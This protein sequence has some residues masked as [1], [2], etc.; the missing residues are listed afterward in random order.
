[1][2][3]MDFLEPFA[4]GYLE[5]RVGQMEARAKEKAERRKLEDN[6]KLQNLYS[7]QAYRQQK[8]IDYELIEKERL[9]NRNTLKNDL[10]NEGMP[11]QLLDI[12]PQ[13]HLED[14]NSYNDFVNTMYGDDFNW[15]KKPASYKDVDGK[16]VD[17]TVA[18]LI[19]FANQNE[20]GITKDA[21]KKTLVGSGAV[22]DGYNNVV[23]NQIDIGPTTELPSM[24]A[25]PEELKEQF[26][27]METVT[28][29]VEEYVPDTELPSFIG[30]GTPS[31]FTEDYGVLTEEKKRQR[32]QLIVKNIATLGAFGE[33]LKLIDGEYQM[34]LPA[35]S[36][37][38]KRYNALVETATKFA[39]E[40]YRLKGKSP[41]AVEATQFA[42][43]SNLFIKEIAENHKLNKLD[44]NEYPEL[45]AA[46]RLN[47][48]SLPEALEIQK[49]EDLK[50]LN[51]LDLG[52]F[53]N[54]YYQGISGL[55]SSLI[56]PDVYDE[57]QDRIDDAV[58]GNIDTEEVFDDEGNVIEKKVE[59]REDEIVKLLET[60]QDSSAKKRLEDELKAIRESKEKGMPSKSVIEKNRKEEIIELL[61]TVQNPSAK[62][63]LED[64]LKNIQ[65]TE[66]LL[67]KSE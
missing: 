42:L 26:A 51:E 12:I 18:S 31:D 43:R 32:D 45:A 44:S 14:T 50:K 15:Y 29:Q 27:E 57:L 19:I 48:I 5:T 36:T 25:Q 63:R 22:L 49:Y 35:D 41:S 24:F 54:Y 8:D 34:V 65:E 66:K 28:P 59:T 7:A 10:L 17:G 67:S 16:T 30:L 60:V 3:L 37:E 56:K 61:E 23:D 55:S 47:A 64:E 21:T 46:I 2:G 1:M 4:T 58:I 6:L 11:S 53:A 33:G 13:R 39:D 62:K 38:S 9:L 20:Q 40:S 52:F